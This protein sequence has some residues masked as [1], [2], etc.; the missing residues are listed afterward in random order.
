M[1]RLLL[2]IAISTALF[3]C[4]NSEVNESTQ[5]QSATPAASPESAKAELGSFGIELDVRDLMLLPVTTF[6]VMRVANG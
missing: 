6:S 5:S 4:G 2:S 3:A 1:K